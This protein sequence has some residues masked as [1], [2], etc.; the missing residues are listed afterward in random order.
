MPLKDTFCYVHKTYTL[1]SDSIYEGM[2]LWV[3]KKVK[4][5]KKKT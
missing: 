3:Y 4:K 2:K 1:S 5:K